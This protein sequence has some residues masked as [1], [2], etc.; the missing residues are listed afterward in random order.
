MLGACSFLAWQ[1]TQCACVGAG[2]RVC[3]AYALRVIAVIDETGG[4]Y[5]SIWNFGF[6]RCNTLPQ[7]AK[8]GHALFRVLIHCL[9]G[10]P[11]HP[12][13]GKG[14]HSAHLK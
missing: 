9:K 2:L 4:I 6:W 7:R 12:Q 8:M 11:K 14:V 13:I 5:D 1:C 3:A 10:L